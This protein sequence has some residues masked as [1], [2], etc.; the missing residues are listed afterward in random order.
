MAVT[1]RERDSTGGQRPGRCPDV[2]HKVGRPCTPVADFEVVPGDTFL[3]SDG[4]HPGRGANMLT[5]GSPAPAQDGPGTR[6]GGGAGE[7]DP[8]WMQG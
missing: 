5:S 6:A 4:F 3:S 8:L 2:K 1:A 7:G